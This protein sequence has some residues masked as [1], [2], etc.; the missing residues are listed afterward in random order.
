MI[1]HLIQTKRFIPTHTAQTVFDIDY[2][3]LY[4][5]KKAILM[6]LDNTLITYK[7]DVPTEKIRQL[8]QRIKKIGFSIILVSNN[9]AKRLEEFTAELEVDFV[10]MA[11]KPFARGY[12]QALKK[13]GVATQDAIMV[14]D[15]MLT[16][17]LGANFIGMDSILVKTIAEREQKWYT[18]I[19]RSTEKKILKR[20]YSEFPEKYQSII[21]VMK[22]DI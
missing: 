6:D 7:E 4:Q 2:E 22:S 16:D 14:G 17:I 18:K 3:T 8:L 1:Y 12:K 10:A 9:H 20:I 15:Q 5:T 11:L 19:N 13:L 21:S